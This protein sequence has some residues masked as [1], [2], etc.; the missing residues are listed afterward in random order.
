MPTLTQLVVIFCLNYYTEENELI[1]KKL[2]SK[3]KFD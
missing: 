3:F 1:K 2:V